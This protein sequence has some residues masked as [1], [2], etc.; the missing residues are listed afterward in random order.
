MI[1]WI[2]VGW[3]EKGCRSVKQM[4]LGSGNLWIGDLIGL[5]DGRMLRGV[6]TKVVGSHTLRCPF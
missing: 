6:E 4:G 5:V 2:F 1:I 3:S